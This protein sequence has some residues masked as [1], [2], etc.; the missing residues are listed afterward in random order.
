[1]YKIEDKRILFYNKINYDELE[2]INKGSNATVY[3]L[4]INDEPFALKLFNNNYHPGINHYKKLLDLNI[5][6]F[7]FPCKLSFFNNRFNG[8][9]M[10]YCDGENL[11]SNKLNINIDEFIKYSNKL[12][13]DVRVLSRLKYLIQDVNLSNTMFNN[14]F[15]IIDTDFFQCCYNMPTALFKNLNDIK[16]FNDK[17]INILLIEIFIKTADIK[18]LFDKN[19][20]L[21][22]IRLCCI[23][24]YINFSKFIEYIC[25]T[26][27]YNID[28]NDMKIEEVGYQ[29][30][31]LIN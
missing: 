22:K 5:D 17:V 20:D 7:I 3:K 29:L 25:K 23:L 12:F 11:Q 14:G 28:Y 19:Y 16:K 18:T 13:N 6:S 24:G 2:Y 27:K 30:K 4:K 1:M 15:K 21:E 31:K 10:N 8:Y 9:L 26:P